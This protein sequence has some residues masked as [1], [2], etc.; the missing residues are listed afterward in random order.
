MKLIKFYQKGGIILIKY[1]NI[2]TFKSLNLK[3]TFYNLKNLPQ[4]QTVKSAMSAAIT[5]N[6]R[7]TSSGFS[8]IS[9][10][11]LLHLKSIKS[12]RF[13][14]NLLVNQSVEQ[15]RQTTPQSPP[16]S[17]SILIKH[18][19]K[20]LSTSFAF[21]QVLTDFCIQS[22]YFYELKNIQQLKEHKQVLNSWNSRNS[23]I[24]LFEKID[25]HRDIKK[26][27]NFMAII[28][29]IFLIKKLL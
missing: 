10:L 16:Q 29:G 23:Y 9:N 17:Y 2:I 6:Y 27:L 12:N 15:S 13:G 11:S 28:Y 3:N 4:L 20:N 14:I 7:G 18:K 21:Y 8:R 5:I 24:N 26:Y 1:I 19:I 25:I 22:L